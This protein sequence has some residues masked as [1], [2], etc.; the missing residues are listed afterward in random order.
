V[1]RRLFAEQ[2]STGGYLFQGGEPINCLI[3][4]SDV[5]GWV[6][7][8]NIRLGKA[9]SLADECKWLYGWL[10]PNRGA[11]NLGKLEWVKSEPGKPPLAGRVKELLESCDWGIIHYAGHSHYDPAK[12]K[13]Y[14]FFPG[15]EESIDKIEIPSFSAWLRKATFVY[16][17]SCDSG[18]GPFMFELANQRVPNLVGFRWPI[19]DE[20]AFE[21]SQAF[22]KS[23]FDKKSLERAFLKARQTMHDAYPDDRSWATPLLIMQLSDS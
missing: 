3:I 22:Y 6:N 9:Q 11:F 4:E 5:S 23:L 20:L 15:A 8:L 21:Y 16:L 10:D 2:P 18:S 13:G 14:V 12:K 19:D 1:Y 17:S 7:D